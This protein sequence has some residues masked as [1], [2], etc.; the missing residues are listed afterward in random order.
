MYRHQRYFYDATRKFYLLGRDQLIERLKVSDN[1]NI[2]EIGCGTG[3]NLEILA[4]RFPKANFFG[5]DASSEMLRTA[6]AKL[7]RAGLGNVTLRTAL[8]GDLD[9]LRTFGMA[10][11]FDTIFFSYSISMIPPWREAIGRAISNLKPGGTLHIVD[12]YDQRDLPI[13]FR[14]ILRTWLKQFH[15]RFW[16]ELIPY[17]HTLEESGRGCLTLEPIAR[18]YAFIAS[19]RKA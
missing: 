17:L 3:R 11:P 4:G 5:L 18:R 19:F 15:V 12:F 1:E 10:E 2:A 8:A 6:A 16:G 14:T 7:Q 9:H 13:W